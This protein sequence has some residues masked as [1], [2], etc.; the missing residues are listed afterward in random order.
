M[1]FLTGQSEF[2]PKGSIVESFW[3]TPADDVRYQLPRTPLCPQFHLRAGVLLLQ[4]LAGP[5]A[6]RSQRPAL[7]RTSLTLFHANNPDD[8]HVDGASG[9]ASSLII[10]VDI[11]MNAKSWWIPPLKR[12]EGQPGPKGTPFFAEIN[13]LIEKPER[14]SQTLRKICPAPAANNGRRHSPQTA[15]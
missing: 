15:P 14:S 3:S 6:P 8:R 2:F 7:S 10:A 5:L 9:V 13:G 12:L 4:R 11:R 1:G